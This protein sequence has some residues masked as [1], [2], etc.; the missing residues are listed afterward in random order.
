M[1]SQLQLLKFP[2][3]RSSYA[4]PGVHWHM[5]MLLRQGVSRPRAAPTIPLLPQY[6]A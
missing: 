3:G 4:L 1:Y 2:N 6:W 5:V